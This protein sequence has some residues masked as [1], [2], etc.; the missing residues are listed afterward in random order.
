MTADNH[1][2]Y[3]QTGSRRSRSC[4]VPCC[5]SGAVKRIRSYTRPLSARGSERAVWPKTYT[6]VHTASVTHDA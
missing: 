6:Q 1:S 2:P 3:T 5:I 4:S